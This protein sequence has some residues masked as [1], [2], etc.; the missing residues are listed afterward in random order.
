[1]LSKNAPGFSFTGEARGLFLF[2]CFLL[3]VFLLSRGEPGHAEDRGGRRVCQVLTKPV[4]HDGPVAHPLH[5]GVAVV[6]E[7]AAD[8]ACLMVVVHVEGSL[9]GVSNVVTPGAG[10]ALVEEHCPVVV[11]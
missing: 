3:A 11:Q 5:G 6:A 2:G 8:G 10:I 7:E 9:A 4:A 1:V